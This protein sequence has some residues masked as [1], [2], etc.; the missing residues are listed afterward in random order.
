M[1]S[2]HVPRLRVPEG[3]TFRQ[4][5]MAMARYNL[6]V[7]HAVK[8]CGLPMAIRIV[9]AA[10][11]GWPDRRKS[12]AARKL[13]RNTKNIYFKIEKAFYVR[14]GMACVLMERTIGHGYEYVEAWG[15]RNHG[16]I[17]AAN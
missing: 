1:V 12:Q 15:C 11:P 17:K 2:K 8:E 4:R 7:F 5:L 10:H 16:R 14:D 6:K 9:D 3:A 13:V